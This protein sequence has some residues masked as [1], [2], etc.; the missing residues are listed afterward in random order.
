MLVEDEDESTAHQWFLPHHA[1]FK[2]SNPEKCR[3]VFDCAAQFKGVSL[4]DV[5]L[6]GPNFLNNLSGVSDQISKG[7]SGS[8]RRHQANVSSVLCDVAGPPFSAF[9][10]VASWATRLR[11]LVFMQ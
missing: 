1:V 5:I 6:Q 4:N 11:S 2:R 3:V 10:L 8:D 7:A 9:P